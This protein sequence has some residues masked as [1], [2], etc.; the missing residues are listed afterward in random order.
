VLF[1]AVGV[2]FLL[3]ATLVFPPQA[4][5]LQHYQVRML[6]K[7]Q[8]NNVI[9]YDFRASVPEISP[10]QAFGPSKEPQGEKNL[11]RPTVIAHSPEA[12]SNKQ[13]IWQPD[14]PQPIP[15]DVPVPNVVALQPPAPKPPLKQF[16]P[17]PKYLSPAKP[18]ASALV[19]PAP[20]LEA[21]KLPMNVSTLAL[22][23][24]NHDPSAL[25]SRPRFV[26]PSRTTRA[27]G[28]ASPQKL[29]EVPTSGVASSGT[30]DGLKAVI[31][32]LDPAP[33]PS[34]PGSRP[35]QFSRAPAEGPPSSGESKSSGAPAVPGLMAHG[36]S[37]TSVSE[38]TPTSTNIP[39]PERHLLK[40]LIL[41]AINRTM[42]V[43]LRPSSRI[44]PA[45]VE[46]RFTGR[47]VF[48]L[49]IPGPNLPDYN[50]DWILW[51]S[52]RHPPDE[53]S[54]RILAPIPV[55]KYFL[56]GPGVASSASLE[57]GTVQL[58]SVI[59]RNGHVSSARILRGGTTGEAFRLK[60]IEELGTWEFQPALRNGDPIEVDMVLEIS[61][62]FRPDLP[63]R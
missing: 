36:A 17:P 42:S 63:V 8:Q 10:T 57:N 56:T 31:V 51:F 55:R 22:E 3:T 48:T 21:P 23:L 32:G 45:S 40:D 14:R 30:G 6:P 24:A 33:G 18:P 13:F 27:S 54:A 59:D 4:P 7:A 25:P 50:G 61:F 41:P 44:I 19:E 16:T 1:H 52:E 43:P 20:T 5:V 53:H 15:S 39:P 34:P 2:A 9:W 58:A 49:V 60:A 11:P 46:A 35:G 26:P 28:D 62:R 37:G 38:P 29:L 12:S 47:D